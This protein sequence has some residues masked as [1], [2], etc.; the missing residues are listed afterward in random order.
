MGDSD[1]KTLM[2]N[3]TTDTD[4]DKLTKLAQLSP[5]EETRFHELNL[6]I[7][8]LAL[9]KTKSEIGILEEQ[10]QKLKWIYNGMLTTKEIFNS[11]TIAMVNTAIQDNLSLSDQVK[12][13]SIDCFNNDSFHKQEHPPG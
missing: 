11:K 9:E 12:T 7:S 3:V 8:N 10:I 6:E 13:L 2:T 1:I 5:D 4:L